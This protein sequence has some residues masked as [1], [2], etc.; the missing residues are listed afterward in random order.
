MEDLAY[1]A[2]AWSLAHPEEA[3]RRESPMLR[4][5]LVGGE[6]GECWNLLGLPGQPKVRASDLNDFMKDVPNK[7]IK[8]AIA[9]LP[10]TWH[11]EFQIKSQFR[12]G[13]EVG[14]LAFQIVP[15]R[16]GFLHAFILV[17]KS[18]L[19]G[20]TPEQVT[21]D[22]NIPT[23]GWNFIYYDLPD[24]LASPAVILDG[25]RF[26]RR[27]IIKY[28]A[29]RLGG[30]H[31]K[32]AGGSRRQGGSPEFDL[33]DQYGDTAHDLRMP[34]IELLAIGQA[35]ADSSDAFR[36]REAAD[37]ALRFNSSH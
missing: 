6:Y 27:T 24:F 11:D 22:C 7:Y 26:S 31:M 20:R 3:I 19:A 9:P 25:R 10:D 28:V 8:S 17:P 35:V 23:G 18:D 15:Q 30:A 13:V 21:D 4:Q 29:N 36:F 32:K 33:L 16:G 12:E 5:L 14:S 1:L 37:R 2:T 34:F